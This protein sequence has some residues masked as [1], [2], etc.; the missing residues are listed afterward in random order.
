MRNHRTLVIGALV[1]LLYVPL[2]FLVPATSGPI[3][4][5][6]GDKLDWESRRLAGWNAT[7]CG[8]VAQ[9]GDARNGSACAVAA[10]KNRK[11]FQVRY[12]MAALDEAYAISIVGAPDGHVY[13]LGFLGGSPDGGVSF[14]AQNVS[15][16]RCP[17][18][19]TFH[20][21]MDWGR[22]DRG[23]ISCRAEPDKAR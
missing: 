22:V 14:R 13:H 15:I 8:R 20:K 9:D 3:V 2:A 19:I 1:L 16:W 10:F 21:E 4:W 17:E 11:S 18:L 5:I 7:N 23:V 6:L 12:E